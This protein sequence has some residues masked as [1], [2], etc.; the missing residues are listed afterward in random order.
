[1][2]VL[3]KNATTW[4][5][6]GTKGKAHMESFSIHNQKHPLSFKYTVGLPRDVFYELFVMWQM[7]FP[8]H[9][10]PHDNPTK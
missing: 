6:N 5:N 8:Q 2:F 1:M 4:S 9:L 10:D 3:M 7:Q